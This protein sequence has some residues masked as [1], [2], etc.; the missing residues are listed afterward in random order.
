MV[1]NEK[2]LSFFTEYVPNAIV[3]EYLSG[4]EITSDVIC[5]LDGDILAVVSRQRIQTRAGEVSKGVTVFDECIDHDCRRIAKNLPAVGPITVQ[6]IMKNGTPHYTEINPRFGGG[7]PLAIAAGVDAPALLLARIAGV[8]LQMPQAGEYR[9]DLYLT[10]YD[11]S[12]IISEKKRD[13]L[14][15]RHL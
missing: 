1:R 7:V 12:F 14:A 11:D 2:E 9:T 10:R 8:D 4:P 15:S 13:S 3:Q 5:D 6:C